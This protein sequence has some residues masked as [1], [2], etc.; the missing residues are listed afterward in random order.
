MW[1]AFLIAV[2]T[3]YPIRINLREEVFVWAQ[4]EAESISVG[5]CPV[6][7]SRSQLWLLEHEAA[8]SHMGGSANG[9]GI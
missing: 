8:C 4:F 6:V 3:N 1:I 2:V 7:G 9:A 5:K